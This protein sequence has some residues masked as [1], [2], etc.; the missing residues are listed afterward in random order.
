MR[1]IKNESLKISKN[2][3]NN[4]RPKTKSFGYQILGMGGGTVVPPFSF[5]FAADA[6]DHVQFTVAFPKSWNESTVTFQSYWSVT[7][8]NTGTVCFALQGKA[9]SSDDAF[10]GAYGTAVPNTALAASGTA[11]D[12]MVNVES[13]AVTIGGSPAAGDLCSFQLFRD[14]SADDQTAAARLVGIKLFFTT[15]AAN[16]V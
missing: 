9:A 8:T 4:T 5:D 13:G 16:D 2:K 7:G 12:L 15:D 10:A 11:N 1:N 3:K 6:D 14:V